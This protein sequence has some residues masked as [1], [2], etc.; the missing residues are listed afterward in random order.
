[1]PKFARIWREILK[2]GLNLGFVDIIITAVFV[3][4]VAFLVIGFNRQMIEKNEKRNE[5]YK[6]LREKK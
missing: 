2:K 1:M 6:N 5:K 3:G 4:F